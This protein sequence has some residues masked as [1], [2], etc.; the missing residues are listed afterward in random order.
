M[1][2]HVPPPLLHA[3]APQGQGPVSPRVSASPRRIV[4]LAHR[5]LGNPA[6]GGSELLVDQLA[7][8]LTERGHDV[9]L[10]CGGRAAQRPYRVVSAGSQL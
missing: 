5:D 9:T 7:L 8:G 4:F 10:L 2:Q 6:A 1:P 3:A